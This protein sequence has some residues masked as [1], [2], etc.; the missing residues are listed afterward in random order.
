VWDTVRR[1]RCLWEGNINKALRVDLSVDMLSQ[2]TVTF[3]GDTAVARLDIQMGRG[4]FAPKATG[5][6]K[7][8]ETMTLVVSVEGDAD[9]DVGVRDC[10]A[11]D[12]SGANQAFKFPDVMDLTL[13]CNVELCKTDCQ[14]CPDAQSADPQLRR[15]RR[16]LWAAEGSDGAADNATRGDPVR[17]FRSFRVVSPDDLQDDAAPR[18][19]T[20]SK[21]AKKEEKELK[22]VRKKDRK[23]DVEAQTAGICMTVPGLLRRGDAGALLLSAARRRLPVL[24]VLGGARRRRRARRPR[25]RPTTRPPR[26][27][28]W[29]TPRCPRARPNAALGSP[30]AGPHPLAVQP[31]APPTRHARLDCCERA[32]KANG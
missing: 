31:P 17:V 9:F 30:P 18:A 4:P 12:A 27:P 15:R 22:I 25:T 26:R 8:G 5:L 29:P 7:I 32:A 1:V 21:D 24:R 20:V 14:T 13:E 19:A 2:E 11:H 10:T 28:T 3:S 6:V 16:D 23:R